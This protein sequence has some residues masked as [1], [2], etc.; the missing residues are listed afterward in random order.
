MYFKYTVKVLDQ[1]MKC[2]WCN[3]DDFWPNWQLTAMINLKLWKPISPFHT[4]QYPKGQMGITLL[5]IVRFQNF[6][7]H[8]KW[9]NACFNETP[10]TQFS[11]EESHFDRM[12]HKWNMKQITLFCLFLMIL[13]MELAKTPF[14]DITASWLCPKSGLPTSLNWET[15]LLQTKFNVWRDQ[16]H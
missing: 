12:G 10:K 7:H 2:K 1:N 14:W 11:T 5:R 6:N 13:L 4:F 9:E 8:Y 3:F 15:S 16:R